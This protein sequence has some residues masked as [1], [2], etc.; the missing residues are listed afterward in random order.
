MVLPDK[1]NTDYLLLIKYNFKK[2]NKLELQRTL[3][4]LCSS[5][6]GVRMILCCSERWSGDKCGLIESWAMKWSGS[7]LSDSE[8]QRCVS[9]FL[10]IWGRFFVQSNIKCLVFTQL[11]F[12][13]P[14]AKNF[15]VEGEVIS[16][17]FLP[18]TTC[19]IYFFGWNCQETF[20]T[21]Q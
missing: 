18:S 6:C 11:L 2:N 21:D 20:P 19:E 16:W 12:L 14:F 9:I 7:C 5:I 17:S 1:R 13:E 3:P 15:K 8:W 4:Q 10:H